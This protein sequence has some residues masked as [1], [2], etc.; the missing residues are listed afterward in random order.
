[1]DRNNQHSTP[2]PLSHFL[3]KIVMVSGGMVEFVK[4]RRQYPFSVFFKKLQKSVVTKK[5]PNNA[6][7]EAQT[8]AHTNR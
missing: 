7:T 5:I 4:K 3:M 6:K 1:M 2:P 8:T